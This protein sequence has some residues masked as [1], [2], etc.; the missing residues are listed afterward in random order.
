MP[1]IFPEYGLKN[2]SVD[3]KPFDKSITAFLLD[4]FMVASHEISLN[5]LDPLGG[6][7]GDIVRNFI[8]EIGRNRQNVGIS[9]DRLF[10]VGQK[11]E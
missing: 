6:G 7:R 2:I 8:A 11:P 1:E 10:V 4:T 9:L 3:R 5:V